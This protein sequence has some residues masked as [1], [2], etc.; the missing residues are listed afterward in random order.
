MGDSAAAGGEADHWQSLKKERSRKFNLTEIG[1]KYKKEEGKGNRA[2]RAD[3]RT[4]KNSKKN[5]EEERLTRASW[6]ER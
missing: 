1:G 2:V 3:Q 4:R 5:T 6:G